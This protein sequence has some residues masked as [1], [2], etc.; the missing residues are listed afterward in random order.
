MKTTGIFL[1]LLLIL[2]FILISSN[3]ILAQTKKEK[4]LERRVD[5]LANVIKNLNNRIIILEGRTADIEKGRY[6]ISA[7]RLYQESIIAS[8]NMIISEIMH[9]SASAYQ[10]RI[11]P[12]S[13]G[14]GG[15]SFEGFQISSNMNTTENAF[16]TSEVFSEKIIFTGTSKLNYGT[17]KFKLDEKGKT[18]QLECTGEFK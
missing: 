1:R 5:S 17:I 14:G 8:K 2:L 18:E 7:E 6:V 10:F 13:M 4:I 12:K 3:L 11:R 15:G 9:L 16:Y